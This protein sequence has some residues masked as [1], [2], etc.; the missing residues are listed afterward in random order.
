MKLRCDH[1]SC[2]RNLSN[3]QIL[4]R[5]KKLSGLQRDANPWPLRNV[6]AMGSNP[7]EALKVLFGLKFAIAITT[8]MFTSQ[9]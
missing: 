6:E 3:L 7:D 2:N 9:F 1:R 4:A 5:K 8:A